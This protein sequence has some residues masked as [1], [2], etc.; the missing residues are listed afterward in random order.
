MT[1]FEDIH[2]V[3]L[4]TKDVGTPR[5]DGTRG[6]GLYEVPFRLSRRAPPEWA[7]AFVHAW[8]H[9]SS[10][11]TMHRPGICRVAGD[12]VI[13][14]R[15]TIE[16]VEKT[17][18]KTLLLAAEAANEY[19][20]AWKAEAAEAQAEKQRKDEEHRKHV[21]NIAQRIKFDDDQDD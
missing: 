8:D 21:R 1:N 17:H 6:S 11:T 16:E 9:P 15:T 13:L 19:V 10:F 20:R 2:I 5:N 4:I 12:R 7:Q 3:E 18:R 14:E